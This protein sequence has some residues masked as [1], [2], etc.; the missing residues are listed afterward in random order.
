MHPYR[1]H[2]C[3]ELRPP[4]AGQ[5]VRLSGWIHRKR[6]HGNLIFIDLRDHYGITQCVT[7]IDAP[8]FK[9]VENLRNECVITVT[10]RVVERTADTV[11][12]KMDTGGVEL[13]I[14]ELVLQ[15]EVQLPLPL[16]VNSNGDF[17]EDTRL[18]YRFLDL[19]REKLH[20]NIVLRS[21]I[22]SSL[23]RRMI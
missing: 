22:I 5:T 11:N 23:R 2:H 4:L 10:G 1:T 9:Q 17:P 3:A 8:I 6:D 15:S 16:Q 20:Q 12:P 18:T 7:D 13:Q 19:R 21:Q 14:E